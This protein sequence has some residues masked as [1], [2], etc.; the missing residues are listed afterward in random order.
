MKRLVQP[1]IGLIGQIIAILLLTMVIEFGASTLLY[2][3]ASQFAVRDDE[4]RRL[5]EH[6]VIA[7]RLVVERNRTDRPSMA[8]DLTTQRYAVRWEEGL[9]APP[10]IAPSVATMHEQVIDWEPTLASADLRLRLT[11]PGRSSVVTG[12]VRLADG[13]WLYFRTLQPLQNL[14][15]AI[16]RIFLALVPAVALMLV[17]AL[18]IRRALR[19]MRQ[20]ALAADL[21]GGG[22]RH[23]PVAE[24]G[25]TEVRRVVAAF[26]RM[27]ARLE[28][29]I[30]DRTHAL[31]AVG[32]DL[33]T[34]LARLRLR[35]DAVGD[36]AT[37]EAIGRDIGEMEAMVTSLLAFLG[38]GDDPEAPVL[39]DVAV[40]CA[41]LIDDVEDRGLAGTYVGPDHCELVVRPSSVKRALTNLVDNALHYGGSATVILEDVPGG[42]TLAVEDDGPGIPAASLKRVLEPFVRLDT[43]R[44]RDTI[45]FGLGLPIV[46]RIVENEG[47]T[48]T[49]ANR[50]PSGL[51]AAIF[52]PR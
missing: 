2:E 9:R 25:P 34:P 26:N 24:A 42:V 40:L 14:N 50:T 15:L 39:T 51:R 29:L 47:G 20:L 27:Q 28:R 43:A 21:V 17:A 30:A 44:P 33:R 45:G 11:S 13:S 3:R 1:S 7:R 6:L 37:R 31:A 46:A 38:G 18:L 4:A 12:G 19:P 49:L 22:T 16:Q 23:V 32:H 36:D 52:L 48:L 8:Q 5:A 41:T 35:A 10:P